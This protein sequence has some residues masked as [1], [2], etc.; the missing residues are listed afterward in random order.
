[1]SFAYFRVEKSASKLPSQSCLFVLFFS[2]LC[3][4]H[5]LLYK[6]VMARGRWIWTAWFFFFWTTFMSF[7]NGSLRQWVEQMELSTQ[8]TSGMILKGEYELPFYNSRVRLVVW[9]QT[10]QENLRIHY[11]AMTWASIFC[12]KSMLLISPCF[13]NNQL[14][15]P[16]GGRYHLCWCFK[17]DFSYDTVTVT[18]LVK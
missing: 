7:L 15:S 11:A 16:L 14:P 18:L 8:S 6:R 17:R 9:L 4:H 2:L 12:Y 3:F 1:M 13:D 5:F 10:Q